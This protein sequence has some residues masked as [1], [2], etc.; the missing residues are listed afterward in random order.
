MDSKIATTLE[1]SRRL[2]NA[3]INPA[4]SDMCYAHPSPWVKDAEN[5]VMLFY[6]PWCSEDIAPAWS[7]SALWKQVAK[8]GKFAFDEKDTPEEIFEKLVTLYEE[9]KNR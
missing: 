8:V 5:M 1:Q 7:L 9:A 2:V 6:E 3:G 4:T